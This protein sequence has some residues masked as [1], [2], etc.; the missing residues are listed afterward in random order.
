MSPASDSKALTSQATGAGAGISPSERPPVELRNISK[1]YGRLQALSSVSFSLP[2]GQIVGLV[3]D[4][5]AGKSTTVK[6]L[7]GV[8]SPSGGS[9]LLDGQ[10]TRFSSPI[11]ARNSGIETVYQDLALAPDLSVWANFFLGREVRRKGPGRV[12]GALNKKAMIEHTREQLTK[13]Q[14]K[15]KDVRTPIGALSGGQ[16]QAVAVARAISWESKV[17]LMDEPTAALGISQ[18][19]RVADLARQAKDSGLAVLIISHDLPWVRALCDQV[20]VLYHGRID[21]VL[22]GATVTVEEMVRYITGATAG[23]YETV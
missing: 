19:D 20:L 15:I 9:L 1:H 21:A 18:R 7:S 4:N 5:G 12:L 6:I 3:G 10:E 22:P 2:R 14:I 23:H 16:R 8:I 11:D 13:L 17:L